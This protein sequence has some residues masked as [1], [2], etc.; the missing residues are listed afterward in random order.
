MLILIGNHKGNLG[1][2]AILKNQIRA[3]YRLFFFL[4]F[5]NYCQDYHLF[6]EIY[7]LKFLDARVRH[8]RAD[9][10]KRKYMLLPDKV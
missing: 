5:V 1:I 10:I 6:V 9:G 4:A 8:I 7:H 2:I 3:P